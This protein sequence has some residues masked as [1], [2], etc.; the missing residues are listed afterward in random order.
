MPQ[1]GDSALSVAHAELGALVIA[2]LE[3]AK[4][5]CRWF[6]EQC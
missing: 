2:K 5:R 4:V 6:S 3:L 1:D